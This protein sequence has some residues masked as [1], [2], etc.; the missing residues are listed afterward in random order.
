ME[1]A[2]AAEVVPG[3]TRNEER[4]RRY[5]RL[6][7]QLQEWT[8]EDAEY[9]EEVWPLV[10]DELRSLRMRC[11]ANHRLQAFCASGAKGLGPA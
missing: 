6:A 7:A 4:G 10:E 9:D 3:A 11:R 5:R 8:A 2:A 1:K